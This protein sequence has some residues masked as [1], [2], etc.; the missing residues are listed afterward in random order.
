MSRMIRLLRVVTACA[1]AGCANQP[2]RPIVPVD[3][4]KTRQVYDVALQELKKIMTPRAGSTAPVNWSERMYLN[5]VVLLPATDSAN[6]LFHDAT[7]SE[8]A[9]AR[10]L[11]T[12]ICGKPPASP[13]P[14]DVPV[15]F[16]S[17]SPVWTK[18]GDTVFVQ[19]GYAGEA[20]GEHTYEAVFWIFTIAPDEETGSLKV[21][22]KGS[23]NRMTF[24]TR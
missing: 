12:G 7:W 1:V 14:P 20:P 4:A 16:T 3:E 23:A 17:L 13:C 19:G 24:E 2:E 21:V 6:P 22:R 10:G 5:P 15:A 9:V 11:V 8:S 18:G